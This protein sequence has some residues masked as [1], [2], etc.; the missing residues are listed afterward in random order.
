MTKLPAEPD[1]EIFNPVILSGTE[2]RK[3]RRKVEGPR[4]RILDHAASGSST[5]TWLLPSK[6]AGPFYLQK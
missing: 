1:P 3:A 6:H 4:G 5:E 2:R